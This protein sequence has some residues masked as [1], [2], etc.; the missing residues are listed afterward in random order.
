M[1][2][3]TSW[4]LEADRLQE[5]PCESLFFG[6]LALVASESWKLSLLRPAWLRTSSFFWS[7][8]QR[9]SS[10]VAFATR[11]FTATLSD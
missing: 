5:D 1:I 8:G 3:L 7:M 4:L 6:A 11:Y 9:T 2:L 10:A